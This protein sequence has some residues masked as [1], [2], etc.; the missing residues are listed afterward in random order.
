MR[1]RVK[2][3]LFISTPQTFAS[4]AYLMR[5]LRCAEPEDFGLTK[6]FIGNGIVPPYAILS[7]T[8]GEDEH[9]VTFKDLQTGA[10]R[11]KA[12]YKKIQFC[13]EQ[14]AKDGLKHFWVDTCCIDKANHTELVEAITSM[15][16]WYHN[17]EK[18]YVYLSD[19]SARERE[20]DQTEPK[21]ESTFPM[22]RWFTRGWTLQELAPKSVDFFSREGQWLGSR[23]TLEREIH[24]TTGIPLTAL[25]G[26][27]LS[28]FSTEE[29]MRWA[30]NRNTKK[31]E[32]KAYCLLGVF[33]VFIPLIYG[34]GDNA[35][36]RLKQAVNQASSGKSSTCH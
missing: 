19:V 5:L 32:D 14:A 36:N 20:H 21:W 15:F 23:N 26:A 13:G 12:G 9:E 2:F 28:N 31:S 6:D 29:R 22:S 7:H 34:E 11:S 35:F 30:A 33:N 17:A 3:Y 27:P 10:G 4:S 8:W 18:C 24:E 16:R 1:T 25:H